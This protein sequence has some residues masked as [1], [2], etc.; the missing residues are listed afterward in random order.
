VFEIPE[1]SRTS[2]GRSIQNLLQL[3][4]EETVTAAFAIKDFDDRDILFCTRSGIVK[5][6]TLSLLRNAARQSGIIACGLE[7]GDSLIGASL[8]EGGEDVLLATAQG[9]SIRFPESDVRRMGRTARG[10]KGI[11]LREGDSVV[12]SVVVQEGACL[13]TLCENGYGKR[14]TFDEYRT[15]SRGGLGIINIQANERNGPVVEVAGVTED[16]DVMLITAG[17]MIV[18]TR[19]AE[20][21]IIGRNT[22][23]VRVINP[24]DGDRLLAAAVVTAEDEEEPGEDTEAE[25]EGNSGDSAPEN[26]DDAPDSAENEGDS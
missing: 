2:A 21:S 20:I 26:R 6:V 23:G 7:D 5:K 10:V 14:T 12:G 19:I 25:S 24:K 18:R 16:D 22:Q 8:L 3:R 15:Q 11:K 1:G 9:M 13:L 4:D 17:G